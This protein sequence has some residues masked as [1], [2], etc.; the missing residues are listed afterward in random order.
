MTLPACGTLS[1]T[2]ESEQGQNPTRARSRV[3][4]GLILI[5]VQQRN[6][7]RVFGATLFLATTSIV[8]CHGKRRTQHDAE[9]FMH[10]VTAVCQICDISPKPKTV[11]KE[12][13]GTV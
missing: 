13:Q 9:L 5:E 2:V 8:T 12:F 11:G 7:P 4:I 10:D 3:N 1:S 6:G